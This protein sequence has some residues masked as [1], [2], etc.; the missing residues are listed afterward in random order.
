M[1]II[2]I[3]N[4]DVIREGIVS[5]ISKVD[6]ISVEFMGNTIN[7]ALFMIKS[8]YADVLLL[9]IH[10]DNK[11]ELDLLDGIISSGIKL[12]LLL[13]DFNGNSEIFVKALKYG[14]QGYILGKANEEELIYAL[15]QIYKGK[16]FFDA[17]FV[18]CIVNEKNQ[19]PNKLDLLTSREREI[20]VEVAK[21]LTNRE[22]SERLYI[23]DHTVKKHINHIFDKLTFNDRTELIFY[24]NKHEIVNK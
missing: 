22:I 18:D 9:D 4:Y 19:L 8:K 6:N 20:L 12:K 15:D 17:Y 16:K 11:D 13:L 21:G 5:V 23:T 14:V 24:L 3:S 1:K 10:D 2:V 7:E